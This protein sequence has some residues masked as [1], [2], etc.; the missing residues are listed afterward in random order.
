PNSPNR[1]TTPRNRRISIQGNGPSGI[2]TRIS[3]PCGHQNPAHALTRTP[4]SLLTV[5]PDVYRLILPGPDLY[6]LNRVRARASDKVL[7]VYLVALRRD[8]CRH[9]SQCTSPVQSGAPSR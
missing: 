9:I 8:H 3:S 5:E 7:C 4:Y 2:L 6:V 1:H